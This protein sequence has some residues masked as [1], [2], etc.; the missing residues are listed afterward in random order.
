MDVKLGEL[1]YLFISYV[2]ISD[3]DD[4]DLRR[5]NVI[6]TTNFIR[7]SESY[8]TILMRMR[9]YRKPHAKL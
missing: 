5:F 6:N 4:R 2:V 7:A 1:T 8:N 3:Q 9:A